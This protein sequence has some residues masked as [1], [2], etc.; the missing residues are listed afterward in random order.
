MLCKT[1][2]KLSGPALVTC[3]WY[4]AVAGEPRGVVDFGTPYYQNRFRPEPQKVDGIFLTKVI[5][6]YV[7]TQ[8][9]WRVRV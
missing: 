5:V 3:V 8:P 2:Y 7:P 4:G 1:G 9:P 6:Q